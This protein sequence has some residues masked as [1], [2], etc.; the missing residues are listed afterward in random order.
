MA[1]AAKRRGTVAQ[2]AGADR[3]SNDALRR[4]RPPSRWGCRRP[5]LLLGGDLQRAAAIPVEPG[6][7]GQGGSR[8]A[9]TAG[10]SRRRR[11]NWVVLGRND[12]GTQAPAPLQVPPGQVVVAG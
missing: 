1:V 3:V 8:L 9:A 5:R 10:S 4:R 6:L 7:R 2:G 11:E 12:Q